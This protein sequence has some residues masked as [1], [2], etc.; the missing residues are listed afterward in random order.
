MSESSA[1]DKTEKPTPKR[2]REAREKGEVARSRE[3]TSFVVVASGAAG[4]MAMSGHLSMA[5]LA[6]MRAA[7]SP[8]PALLDA[9]TDI[10]RHLAEMVGAGF[11]AVMPL[12]AVG[13]IAALFGPLLLGGW[14]LSGKALMPK[15]S[16][17]NPLSGL[18]RVFSS[19]ALVELAKA[20]L[21]ALLLGAIAAA[22]IAAH[23][24][25]LLTLGRLPLEQGIATGLGL[26]LACLLWVTG[27]LLLI[28]GID[29]PWQRYSHDKKLRM[30][31]DEVRREF[32]EM[33]GSP[34]VKGRQRRLQHELANARMMEAVPTADVI[35]T[36]PTHYAVALRYDANTMRAP[37]VVAKGKDLVALAIRELAQRHGVPLLPAPPLARALYRQSKLE[38]EIPAALYLAVAQVLTYLHQLRQWKAQARR[39]GTPP[40]PPVLNDVP[41]GEPDD[42]PI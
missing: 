37:Q 9:P 36:N 25:E 18:K 42:N 31:K 21:K 23:L 3:L 26:L 39:A 8:D 41:G 4:V 16:R 11:M 28:A 19:Q 29:A 10:T 1:Q 30:T 15:F 34:E 14:N 7:L 40:A 32:K 24:D 35:I 6:W 2:L 12:L 22:F 27:G 13:F 5:G 17:V 20:V 33:E 38:A